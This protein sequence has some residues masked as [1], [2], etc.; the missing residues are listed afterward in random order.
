MGRFK[1][2]L[3][4]AD[5][6]ARLQQ[7]PSPLAGRFNILYRTGEDYMTP[8]QS[9]HDLPV[10]EG[11]ARF[12]VSKLVN[13]PRQLVNRQTQEVDT[14][15]QPWTEI[16]NPR[17]TFTDFLTVVIEELMWEG[18]VYVLPRFG[19][20]GTLRE[21]YAY[22]KDLVREIEP[23]QTG[24]V[25]LRPR[26]QVLTEDQNW[27]EVPQLRQLR[28]G[29]RPNSLDGTGLKQSHMDLLMAYKKALFY[30]QK[31]YDGVM[32]RMLTGDFA[33]MN[34]TEQEEFKRSFE[35]RTTDQDAKGEVIFVPATDVK[36]ETLTL[37][38]QQM[39]HIDMLKELARSIITQGFGIPAQMMNLNDSGSQV[40]YT[41]VPA[42]SERLYQDAVVH[43][44][45]AI[46]DGLS[47][48]FQRYR[49][50]LDE[51]RMV[52]GS[53]QD[54]TVRAKSMADINQNMPTFTT[55]EIR[56]TAGFIG[57]NA[58]I[59]AEQDEMKRKQA[60]EEQRQ[61]DQFD[62]MNEQNGDPSD[63]SDE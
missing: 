23:Q 33:H 60:E 2:W 26:W 51:R 38:P 4:G 25:P 62:R 16:A 6:E 14:R 7:V 58:E 8:P 43:Y 34:D 15:R 48:L 40:S 63:N 50:R 11:A 24:Y 46:E 35:E 56:E 42:L 13:M 21:L 54:M 18:V 28:V 31:L 52:A 47:R 55:E 49:F 3:T 37:D 53:V 61:R 57:R 39:A 29:A 59:Q 30:T 27:Q 9:I 20:D 19:I 32:V 17:E 1:D 12:I 22:R 45:V 10:T 44:K 5:L 41:T 36:V